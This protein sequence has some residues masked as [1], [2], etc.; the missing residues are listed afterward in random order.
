MTT[1]LG[2]MMK[3]NWCEFILASFSLPEVIVYHFRLNYHPRK[4]LDR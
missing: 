2:T 4:G 3:R 1:K